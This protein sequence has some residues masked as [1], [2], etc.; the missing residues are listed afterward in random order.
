MKKNQN[1][2]LK[3]GLCRQQ[4]AK[5][6]AQIKLIGQSSNSN[7]PNSTKHNMRDK[8]TRNQIDPK[9]NAQKGKF[10]WLRFQEKLLKQGQVMNVRFST[11]SQGSSCRLKQ[12]CWITQNGSVSDPMFIRGL[13]CGKSTEF[14]HNEKT[15]IMIFIILFI[16]YTCSFLIY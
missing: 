14:Y 12:E 16:C 15:L 11:N 3:Q 8:L 13:N 1:V 9:D 5:H 10:S 6:K 2:L 7:L 4:S